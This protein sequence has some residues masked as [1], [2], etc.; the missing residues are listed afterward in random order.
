VPFSWVTS[1]EGRN[2]AIYIVLGQFTDQGIR[3]I[4]DTT[5][6]AEAFKTMAQKTGAVVKDIYWTLGQYDIAAIIEAPDDATANV[7]LVSL[8]AQGNVRT[9][10]LRAFSADEI[11]QALAKLV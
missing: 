7:L 4:K 5:K 1:K 9:Q 2:M 11:G 6:R 3:N 10:T 8:G